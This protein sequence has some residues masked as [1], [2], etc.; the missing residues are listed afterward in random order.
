MRHGGIP[1][2]YLV[3]DIGGGSTEFVRGS[4][5]VEAALSVDIGCVRMTERHLRSDPPHRGRDRGGTPRHR[6]RHRRGGIGRG[7]RG[8]VRALVGLAGSVTTVTAH[9]L[10]LPAYDADVTHLAQATPAAVPRCGARAAGDD[11][12]RARRAA[13]SCTPAG[14]TSS[15][16]GALVW[17][18]VIA[19]VC[20]DTG[21]GEELPVLA[22]EHDILDGVALSLVGR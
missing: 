15:A 1:G 18:R 8:T 12:R 9:V 19:R 5:S 7:L 16:A 11:P 17:D 3:V 10:D 4:G 20:R 22:S 2:P 13:A 21:L 6:R 14:S